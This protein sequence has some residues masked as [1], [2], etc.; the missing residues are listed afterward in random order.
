MFFVFLNLLSPRC[1]LQK[2]PVATYNRASA[3]TAAPTAPILLP[4]CRLSAALV[5]SAVAAEVAELAAA[6]ADSAAE[7]IDE[8]EPNRQS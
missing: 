3:A 5:L 4:A 7:D 2:P 6:V 1:I 8:P